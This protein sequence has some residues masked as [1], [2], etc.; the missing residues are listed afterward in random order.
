M[1][2]HANLRERHAARVI[3]L[4]NQGRVLLMRG[5]DEHNP[6]RSWWFTM[7]GGIDPG[8]TPQQAA[9][10]EVSEEAGITLSPQDLLGPILE[11]T[12]LFDFAQEHIIQHEVFYLAYVADDVAITRDG[13]TE[14]ERSFVDDLAWMSVPELQNS[15]CEVFPRG[16]PGI[17]ANLAHGWDGTVLQLGL[18]DENTTIGL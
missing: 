5:H 13:W 4:N 11:R 18:E 14:V 1:T 3:L 6:S 17:L 10:R 2:R 12:A 15:P 7:G 8:E 16:L 9:I